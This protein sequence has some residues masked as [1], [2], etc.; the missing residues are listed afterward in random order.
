MSS[1]IEIENLSK[2][3]QI[4]H[5]DLKASRYQTFQ[6]ELINAVKKPF[7]WLM[8]KKK[9]KEDFWALKNVSF[10]VEAGEVFGLIGPNGAGKTTLLKVLTRITSPNKGKAIIRGRVSS[11]LE[12]GTGFH[13][14]LTG[15]ENIYLNGAILGMRKKD[16]NRKFNE[17]VSFAEVEK[18]L[19]MPVKRYSSGM[20]VRLAFSV[21]A[22]LE[23]DVFLVDEVLSVG[24]ANFQKKSLNKM[25]EITKRGD[26]TIIF[27]S[28]N[29]GAVQN[30]C[31]RCA[32]LNSGQIRMVGESGQ[33]VRKYLDES[34]S[35]GSRTPFVLTRDRS[36]KTT[37]HLRLKKMIIEDAEGREIK[38]VYSGQNIRIVLHYQSK[39]AESF[40]NVRVGFNIDSPYGETITS[41]YNYIA[42]S[43][44][45]IIPSNGRF[46]IKIPD[47]PLA[48]GVYSCTCFVIINDYI[49]AD[50]VDNAGYIEV[51]GDKFFKSNSLVPEGQAIFYIK[52]SWEVAGD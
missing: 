1:I 52:H 14:E 9:T 39:Q 27:V 37:G 47:F 30:L 29:L 42:G 44:F 6:E 26:R 7:T 31:R 49:Y 32:L 12:V 4:Q 2:K 40:K 24:D 38:N 34:I 20:Y 18:F 8:G 48:P 13:P 41:F 5:Q 28:H 16:I 23:P 21:A 46:I 11:L 10:K 3:Y 19:D 50:W 33:V 51:I 43:G 22:H 25:E 15:R 35:G 17:I 45:E 36:I